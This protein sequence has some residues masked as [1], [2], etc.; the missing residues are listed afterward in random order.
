MDDSKRQ[1]RQGEI[2]IKHLVALKKGK[3]FELSTELGELIIELEGISL[4]MGR[5]TVTIAA[6]SKV[7]T[8]ILGGSYAIWAMADR[9]HKRLYIA[10]AN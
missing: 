5:A 1:D 6:A 8:V 3:P 9:L 10:S 2:K 7:P 4:L